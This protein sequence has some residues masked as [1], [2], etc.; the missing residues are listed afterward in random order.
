M[1]GPPKKL[2]NDQLVLSDSLYKFTSLLSIQPSATFMHMSPLADVGRMTF[3]ALDKDWQWDILQGH[4]LRIDGPSDNTSCH[5]QLPSSWWF[6]HTPHL[7]RCVLSFHGAC[8]AHSLL[9]H[10]APIDRSSDGT[11]WWTI[12]CHPLMDHLTSHLVTLSLPACVCAPSHFS[13]L[14]IST[15]TSSPSC[16]WLEIQMSS[17]FLWRLVY[18]EWFCNYM[19]CIVLSEKTHPSSSTL[20]D[21][22]II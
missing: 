15:D 3:F 19:N 6:P 18:V 20:L 1:G 10:L 21:A 5:C 22:I 17:F 7:C 16:H 9:G 11:H 13:K 8:E 2:K 4:L 12:W 14:M